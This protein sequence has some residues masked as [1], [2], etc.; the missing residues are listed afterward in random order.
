MNNNL[1]STFAAIAG[2]IVVAGSYS[3]QYGLLGG[4]HRALFEKKLKAY[5]ARKIAEGEIAAAT[6]GAVKPQPVKA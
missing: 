5:E 4:K 2:A 3:Y 6:N 1:H